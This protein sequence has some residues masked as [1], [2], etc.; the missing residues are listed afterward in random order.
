MNGINQLNF[1]Y[2]V[3][4]KP[5]RNYTKFNLGNI[6]Y[7]NSGAAGIYFYDAYGGLYEYGTRKI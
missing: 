6:S 2:G 3:G 4:F 1:I 7:F 5:G